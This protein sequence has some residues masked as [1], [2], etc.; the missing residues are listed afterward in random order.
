[1]IEDGYCRDAEFKRTPI[2]LGSHTVAVISLFHLPN[3][4]IEDLWT[5]DYW[6]VIK[7]VK[8]AAGQF[9]AALED[10]WSPAFLMALRRTITETLAEHDK[11]YGTQFASEQKEQAEP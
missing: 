11:K 7:E 8:H 1:M 10:H 3:D 6:D 2:V 4:R 5:Y 9:I